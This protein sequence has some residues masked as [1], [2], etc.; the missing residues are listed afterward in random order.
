VAF[1][2]PVKNR[3]QAL[4]RTKLTEQGWHLAALEI[5]PNHGQLFVK[6][7]PMGSPS[8]ISRQYGYHRTR[9]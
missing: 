3:W 2:G 8:H 1:S 7:H 4:I 6:A 9:P 5:M